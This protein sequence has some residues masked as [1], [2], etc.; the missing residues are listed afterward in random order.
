MCSNASESTLQLPYQ[1]TA[2]Q[3]CRTGLAGDKACR[4]MASCVKAGWYAI[5]AGAADL[6]H[7]LKEGLFL[8]MPP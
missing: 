8:L 6:S 2:S 7:L 4:G 5:E 3:N 1:V